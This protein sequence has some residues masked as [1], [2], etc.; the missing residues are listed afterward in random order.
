MKIVSRKEFLALPAGTVYSKYVHCAFDTLCIKGETLFTNADDWF[1]QDI[2]GAV[3]SHDMREFSERLIEA[4]K[5]GESIAMNFDIQSR[6]GCFESEQMFAV[7]EEDDVMRLVV[8]LLRAVSTAF[9]KA[10]VDD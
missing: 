4:S 3:D 9:Y 5:T 10:K 1:Y 2:A 6:D 7:W 8:R